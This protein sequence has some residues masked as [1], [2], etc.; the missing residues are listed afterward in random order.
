MSRALFKKKEKFMGLKYVLLSG[1]V[2]PNNKQE[3]TF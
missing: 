3:H 2:F 1:S